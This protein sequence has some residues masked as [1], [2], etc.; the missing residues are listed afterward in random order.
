MCSEVGG[1]HRCRRS[2]SHLF[3]LYFEGVKRQSKCCFVSRMGAKG[4]K[5]ERAVCNS[6]IYDPE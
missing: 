6:I 3:M 1:S 2:G 5:F 4:Y